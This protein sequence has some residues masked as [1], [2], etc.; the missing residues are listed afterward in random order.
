[1][2][3]N[4]V[5]HHHPEAEITAVATFNHNGDKFQPTTG[6]E[7]ADGSHTVD[8]LAERLLRWFPATGEML[9]AFS[10]GVDSSLVLAAALRARGAAN[11]RAVIADSP[12]LARREFAEALS[13]AN[14]FGAALTI[15][16][17]DELSRPEYVKNDASRCFHCKSTL[18]QTLLAHPEF[19]NLAQAA[20][21]LDGTNAD[22]LSDIRPGLQAANAAGVRHPL[23]ECGL[24]KREV[25]EI[26]RMWA[27]PTWNKPEMACL[28]S[29]IPHGTTVTTERLSLVEQAEVALLSLGFSGARVRLHDLSGTVPSAL[30][31]V[32]FH[33]EE[34]SRAASEPT[35]T[36]IAAA[37]RAIGF[38]FV[39]LDLEGY[40]K[41]GRVLP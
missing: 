36:A 41:G 1:M 40:R 4:S 23:A 9:V 20:L 10:G 21:V 37:L 33:A 39:T 8:A 17:T 13:L 35:R 27:L 14:S 28:S 6:H 3:T 18:Y 29:R 32:E 34:I 11:V 2:R 15:I 26:S 7:I 31:R 38:A 25:R 24:T 12:S 19:Q 16:E 22:D 30:A 5:G